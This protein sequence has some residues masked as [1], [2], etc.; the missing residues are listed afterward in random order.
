M[1]DRTMIENYWLFDISND[2]FI[3]PSVV[4]SIGPSIDCPWWGIVLGAVTH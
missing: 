3:G 2:L 4:L 1:A